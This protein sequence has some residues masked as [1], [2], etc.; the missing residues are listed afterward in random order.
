MS[1]AVPRRRALP[2][3]GELPVVF[4]CVPTPRGPDG[5][6]ELSFIEAVAA[7]YRGVRAV[8]AAGNA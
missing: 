8:A 5:S 6:A 4:G 1:G 2:E 3:R 7:G